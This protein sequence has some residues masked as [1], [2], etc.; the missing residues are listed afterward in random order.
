MLDSLAMMWMYYTLPR[1]KCNHGCITQAR[2]ARNA[3]LAR[4]EV[5]SSGFE[6]PNT[7]A[8][9]PT[10]VSLFS[11]VSL[12][13]L[14]F[15]GRSAARIF[16]SHTAEDLRLHFAQFLHGRLGRGFKRAHFR[17][18]YGCGPLEQF[19]IHCLGRVVHVVKDGGE[20]L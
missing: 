19:F 1:A 13:A 5:R 12:L 18:W 4:H 11:Q 10:P 20:P 3:R 15:I 14:P 2:R 8:F 7:S 9:R 16:P 17:L 6:V